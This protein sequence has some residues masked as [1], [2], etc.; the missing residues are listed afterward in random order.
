MLKKEHMI[1]ILVLACGMIIGICVSTCL[2]CR[3]KLKEHN[4]QMQKLKERR[5]KESSIAANLDSALAAQ[6]VQRKSD[7]MRK[8]SDEINNDDCHV[9][10]VGDIAMNVMGNK[11]PNGGRSISRDNHNEIMLDSQDDINR[12]PNKLPHYNYDH[13]RCDPPPPPPPPPRFRDWSAQY[14]GSNQC[15]I[16]SNRTPNPPSYKQYMAGTPEDSEIDNDLIPPAPPPPTSRPPKTGRQPSANM[17]GP[18]ST[19]SPQRFRAEAV[20]EMSQQDQRPRSFESTKSA[21][22]VIVTH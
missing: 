21:P 8:Y 11:Y 16:H 13:N 17:T 4:E 18:P 7:R 1:F 3:R 6:I 14:D 5:S 22:D 9:P 12:D 19:R 20:I 2:R 10:D 15:A